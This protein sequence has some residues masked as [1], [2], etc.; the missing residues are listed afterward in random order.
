MLQQYTATIT[1]DGDG[2]ATVYIG[3]SVRGYIQAIKY[4]PGTLSSANLT[5][6]GETSEIPILAKTGAGTSTVWYY[7]RAA[8]NLNSSGAAIYRQRRADLP[9][10]G[11]NEADGGQRWRH[12][13]R[14]HY[15]VGGR[16]SLESDNLSSLGERT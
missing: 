14:H 11:A 1:T 7:P 6:I 15:G 2:D 3:S 16:R 12:Q 13:N 10:L 5:L 8:A 4:E 9:V